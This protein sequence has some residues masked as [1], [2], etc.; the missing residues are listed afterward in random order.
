MDVDKILKTN[1]PLPLEGKTIIHLTL[2]HQHIS[3]K[4]TEALK[5]FDVSVQQFNVLRI[6]KGQNGKAANLSTLNERMVSKMSNTTRLVDKLI[7]KKLVKRSI[8]P[9]NRRK[10]E[11][12]ITKKGKDELVKMSKAMLNMEELLLKNVT[13]EDL[14]SLNKLLNKLNT[15]N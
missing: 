8:C 15:D 9:D 12:Y 4:T 5:P 3:E 7:L 1:K 11:I 2:V 10:I 13:Q 6:L 14:I